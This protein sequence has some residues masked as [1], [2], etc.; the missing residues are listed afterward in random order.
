MIFCCDPCLSPAALGRFFFLGRRIVEG[1]HDQCQK[2]IE[3]ISMS[4]LGF[5]SKH[6]MSDLECLKPISGHFVSLMLAR[7]IPAV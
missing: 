5:Q 6:H 1:V 4:G 2:S 7:S 3:F